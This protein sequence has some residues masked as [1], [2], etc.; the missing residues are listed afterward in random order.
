MCDSLQ[1]SEAKAA[2]AEQDQM[3]QELNEWEKAN[4]SRELVQSCSAS[5]MGCRISVCNVQQPLSWITGAVTSHNLQTKVSLSL[6][7]YSENSFLHVD[8]SGA[9]EECPVLM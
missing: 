4:R 9:K 6:S 2:L 7:H 3:L 8:T 5:L 1:L